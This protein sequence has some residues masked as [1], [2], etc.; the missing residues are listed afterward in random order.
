MP[1]ARLVIPDLAGKTLLVTGG[2]TGIGA[3]IARG[4]AGQGAKVA[5]GCH[6]SEAEA[7]AVVRGIHARAARRSSS[8]GMSRARRSA[9][10]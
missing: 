9:T 1:E 3:A 6:S 2:S 10:A 8:G 5:V 7:Q 4:F